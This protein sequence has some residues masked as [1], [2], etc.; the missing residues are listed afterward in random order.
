MQHAKRQHEQ[1]RWR[2]Q[3]TQLA[4]GEKGDA[5]K[6]KRFAAD[7]VDEQADGDTHHRSGDRETAITAPM[8]VDDAPKVIR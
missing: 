5:V 3:I 4:G 7:A 2:P 8:T 1:N 6:Q